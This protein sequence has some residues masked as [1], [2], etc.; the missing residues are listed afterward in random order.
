MDDVEELRER[1]PLVAG[2]APGRGA[3]RLRRHPA[4]RPRRPGPRLAAHA[5]R[6]RVGRDP[7]ADRARRPRPH[8]GAHRGLDHG[9]RHRRG[10]ALDQHGRARAHGRLAPG[11][12]HARA[13]DDPPPRDPRGRAGVV[14][15]VLRAGRRQR[16]GQPVVPSRARRRRLGGHGTEGVVL[17]RPGGRPRHPP[18]PHRPR[19]PAPRRHLVLPGRHARPGHR[20]PAR[21]AR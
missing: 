3:T 7:L 17:E 10:A 11:L 9:V 20:G 8:P 16:P 2:R 6:G 1:R 18:R 21:C 19:G 13:A 12:R 15:A 4:A 5:V 14:P